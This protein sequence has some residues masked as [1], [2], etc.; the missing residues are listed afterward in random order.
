[1][2]L[3]C[4]L[5]ADID[6]ED[7]RDLSSRHTTSEKLPGGFYQT[8]FDALFKTLL[9]ALFDTILGRWPTKGAAIARFTLE[10][11]YNPLVGV[12]FY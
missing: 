11:K 1:M 5:F 9:D 4:S 7:L 3:S 12:T 2:L 6:S 10:V 8:L